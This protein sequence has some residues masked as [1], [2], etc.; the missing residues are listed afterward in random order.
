MWHEG[1]KTSGGTKGP[2]LARRALSLLESGA[3]R[4]FPGMPQR[5]VTAHVCQTIEGDVMTCG[6]KGPKD[7]NAYLVLH[8]RSSER[9]AGRL[10]VGRTYY[11]R[12]MRCLKDRHEGPKGSAHWPGQVTSKSGALKYQRTAQHVI[13]G[14]HLAR[15]SETCR[16][17]LT[18]GSSEPNFNARLTNRSAHTAL[19]QQ[20][21]I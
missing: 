7:Q 19:N 3:K 20:I 4:C 6:T 21:S 1:P 10:T 15:N 18:F 12:I 14:R 2:K 17:W 13:T 5:T 11:Q 8:A 16:F 9:H